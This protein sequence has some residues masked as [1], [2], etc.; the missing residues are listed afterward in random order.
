MDLKVTI[1]VEELF[2]DG[3]FALLKGIHKYVSEAYG[4]TRAD[5]TGFLQ[6][7]SDVNDYFRRDWWELSEKPID[8]MGD[9]VTIVFLFRLLETTLGW[10]QKQRDFTPEDHCGLCLYITY[11]LFGQCTTYPAK[12]FLTKKMDGERL[13][14]LYLSVFNDTGLTTMHW[15]FA[16]EHDSA[17]KRLKTYKN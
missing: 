12:P 4:M 13:P 8:T 14:D 10:Y 7:L 9:P 11:A 15:N 16:R 3:V 5:R 2:G 1:E 6:K 17:L